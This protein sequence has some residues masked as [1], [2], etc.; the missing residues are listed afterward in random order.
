MMVGDVWML[1]ILSLLL[2][3]L[4][5]WWGM[6]VGFVVVLFVLVR[7]VFLFMVIEVMFLMMI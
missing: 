6:N 1:R 3:V 4:M 2:F 7:K 5:K